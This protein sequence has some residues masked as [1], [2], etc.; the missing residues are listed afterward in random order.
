MVELDPLWCGDYQ[1]IYADPPWVYDDKAAAGQRGAG[2]KYDL[3]TAEALAALP[4][5]AIAAPDCVLAMWWVP[6]QPREALALIDAW[7]FKLKN[8]KG[9]TWVKETANGKRHFGMGHWTRANSEDCLIATRGK[10]K[11]ANAGVSQL[12]V[13]KTREHSRKPDEVREGL[14]TLC[15][16]VPRIELF[17]RQQH[18]GW[19]CWGNEL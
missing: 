19:D 4:I 1:L 12:V 13:A 18:P 5:A 10:P 7:G 3:M 16:D 11:R 2:F 15:G 6:P 14:V 9:F 17:A 8:M